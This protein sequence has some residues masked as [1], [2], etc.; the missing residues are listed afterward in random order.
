M[1]QTHDIIL[2]GAGCSSM[3]WLDVYHHK[4]PDSQHRVLM[5]DKDANPPERTWCFWSDREHYYDSLVSHRWSR[6][7]F[8]SP[9]GEVIQDISDFTYQYISGREFF[10]SAYRRVHAD[11]RID[12]V[13]AEVLN[14]LEAGGLT[15]V[16]TDQG[17]FAAPEVYSSVPDANKVSNYKKQQGGTGMW[18]HF[19]GWFIDTGEDI[20]DPE[21]IT[22]MDFRTEQKNGAVFFY[23]LPFSS[24]RALVECTVFGPEIWDDEKYDEKLREYTERYIAAEVNITSSEKGQIPM[25]MTDFDGLRYDG[26]RSIGTAAGIVKPS[27]GYMFLRSLRAVERMVGGKA[28]PETPPRFAFYDRLLLGI[29]RDE[30]Q[31]ISRIMHSLFSRNDFTHVFR[32][33][34]EQTSLQEDVKMLSTLPYTPFIK[35]LTKQTLSSKSRVK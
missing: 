19:R 23:V 25:S 30:P 16:E 32:F 15:Q 26:T 2:I 18:Q 8:A 17:I 20:F 33:L 1:Q 11:G 5:I 28:R 31:Q 6:V 29:I 12:R 21:T 10:K 7:K 13:T 27:T 9:Q 4:N 22:L 14:T 3:Q 34:D 24:R 35:Q